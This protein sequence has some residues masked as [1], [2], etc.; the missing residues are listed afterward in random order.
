MAKGRKYVWNNIH[1]GNTFSLG[2]ILFGSV[3]GLPLFIWKFGGDINHWWVHILLAFFLFVISGMGITFGYHRL[4]SH[5]AFKTKW[6]VKLF[7]LIGGATA[8]QDSALTWSSDHRR[9]HKHVDHEDDPYNIQKG[10]WHAH[11][12]WIL[13]KEKSYPDL[14]NV[15]DLQADKIVMWQHRWWI[16]IALLV[17]FALPA[18]VGWM[19][20]KS[21][22]GVVLGLLLGG[23]FRLT[24]VHH[25]TFFINS[26]CHCMGTQPYSSSH[27]AKDSWFMALLTFGEGYHNYHHEFQ[28]DY[29]NGVKPW[30]FDPTKWAAWLLSKV[31]LASDLRRVPDEKIMLA[32]IR[33]K[34]KQLSERLSNTPRPVCENAQALF[35]EA[36]EKLQAAAE[37]WERAKN[38]YAKAAQKK[39]NL[40]KEQLAELRAQ[41]EVAVTELR[42]AIQQWHAA[43]QQLAGQLA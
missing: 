20:E 37:S 40:T 12:G 1:L 8:M 38:E 6:P 30:Q 9:H 35:A 32:E 2:L 21:W 5:R 34:Q 7:S 4:L 23:M 10:F 15:K 13:F 17:G 36:G 26:L 28:H 14:N 42:E 24:A 29:R 3:V 43:H 41:F 39:I 33:Q 16:V 11:I 25:S 31:G 22:Q 18:C 27:S 19:V